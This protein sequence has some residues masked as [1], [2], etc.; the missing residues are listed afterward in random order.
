MLP[1]L[2]VAVVT[3]TAAGRKPGGLLPG[4]YQTA[5]IKT[6]NKRR[7]GSH[8]H[9]CRRLAGGL[10]GSLAGGNRSSGGV[11]NSSGFAFL[12]SSVKS[13]YAAARELSILPSRSAAKCETLV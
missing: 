9:Q 13:P 12:F 7:T 11:W 2:A 8:I 6:P 3:G 5:Q 4:R 1:S 10:A